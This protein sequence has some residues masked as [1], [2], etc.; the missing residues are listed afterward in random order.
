MSELRNQLVL[1]AVRR[2][3]KSVT[4]VELLPLIEGLA[5]NAGWQEHQL[6][7]LTLRSIGRRLAN[8]Q[9]R[10]ELRACGTGLDARGNATTPL[11]EPADGVYNPEAPI[12]EPPGQGE[13]EAT[14]PAAPTAVATSTAMSD[15]SPFADKDHRQLLEVLEVQDMALACVARFIRDMQ[16]ISEQARRRL[17]AAGLEPQS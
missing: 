3:G 5:T 12:P 4:S 10:G 6:Q 9:S 13:A 16:A 14:M 17:L 2:A 7:D 1:A 11:Y 8:L 15:E